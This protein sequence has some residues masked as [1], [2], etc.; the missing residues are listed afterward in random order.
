MKQS[1]M[2]IVFILA[3]AAL[4]AFAADDTGL[5]L[6]KALG[7]ANGQAL[8]CSE[9]AAAQRAKSLM[10]AHAPRSQSYGDA[11]QAGTNE[12]FLAQTREGVACPDADAL[13]GRLDA[14]AVKLKEALPAAEPAR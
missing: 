11:F 10:L 7:A 6:V 9:M 12:A 4:N 5:A 2:L 3:V 13:S 14:L 8:A 1:L